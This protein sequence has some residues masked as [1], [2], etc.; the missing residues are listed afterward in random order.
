MNQP[1]S[2]A[3]GSSNRA[4]TTPDNA[5]AVVSAYGA[6]R[7][8]LMLL[9]A[10]SFF[11]GFSLLTQGV[12]ALSFGG[13]DQAAERA[14]GAH[15]I[16]LA[17]VYALIGWRRAEYR[18]FVWIPYAAQLAIIVPAF[19][20]FVF[21]GPSDD[22]LLLLLVSIIFFVLLVYL[23][24]SSHPLGFFQPASDE[25]DAELDLED[26]GDEPDAAPLDDASARSRRYRRN[27]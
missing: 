13:Q 6:F 1:P 15:M 18:Y 5:V 22:G 4:A 10:W 27:G 9:A 21:D 17:P 25:D 24:M 23:W 20:G 3:A 26:A 7:L 19:W 2:G 14:V 12:G 11:A 8:L 16:V